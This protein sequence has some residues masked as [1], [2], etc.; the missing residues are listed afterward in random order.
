MCC[1]GTARADCDSTACFSYPRSPES[2]CQSRQIK[3]IE[4]IVS[5]LTVPPSSALMV[6]GIYAKGLRNGALLVEHLPSPHK[7]LP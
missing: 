2:H 3:I 4:V 6:Q 1:Q 7:A 5:P